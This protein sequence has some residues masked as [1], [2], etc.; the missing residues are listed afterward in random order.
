MCSSASCGYRASPRSPGGA[1]CGVRLRRATERLRASQ[2]PPPRRRLVRAVRARKD[3]RERG[4]QRAMVPPQGYCA[5]D[6]AAPLHRT[7]REIDKL[8]LKLSWFARRLFRGQR[9]PCPSSRPSPPRRRSSRRQWPALVGRWGELTSIPARWRP[10]SAA[11]R[12]R[13]RSRASRSNALAALAREIESVRARDINT[14]CGFLRPSGLRETL[15]K[16]LQG[17]GLSCPSDGCRVRCQSM[18]GGG[19]VEFPPCMGLTPAQP[20]PQPG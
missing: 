9:P 3:R 16:A 8:I 5:W 6:H 17:C 18:P 13:V 7:C 15:C 10:P 14:L 19:G 20:G 2:S 1:C 12:P 11:A 4:A